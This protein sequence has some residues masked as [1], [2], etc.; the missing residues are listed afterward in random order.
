[1]LALSASSAVLFYRI[2]KN[3]GFMLIP[4]TL[5]A[6]FYTVLTWSMGNLAKKPKSQ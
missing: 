3:A 6:G 4:Y 2:H 5:W 1:M